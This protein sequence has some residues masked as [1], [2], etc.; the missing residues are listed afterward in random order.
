[1][2][3]WR[4]RSTRTTTGMDTATP[5]GPTDCD[6]DP[7]FIAD[8]TDCDDAR[9]E[10]H[11]GAEEVCDTLDNDCDGG[12]DEGRRRRG[13]PTPDGDGFGVGGWRRGAREPPGAGW[14][15]EP[16]DC[17]DAD[18]LDLPWGGRSP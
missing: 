18:P 14:Q 10:V 8:G 15:S 6:P 16:G 3:V 17:D 9:A 12:V 2:R 5:S 13:T 11:P 4:S 1:M 7:S